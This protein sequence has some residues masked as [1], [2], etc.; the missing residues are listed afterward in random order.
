MKILLNQV[1]RE[2]KITLTKLENW[3]GISK[4]TLNNY[5]N[6]KTSPNMD[7][8]ENLAEALD[9]CIEDLYESKR[10]KH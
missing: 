2:R 3:T 6:G 10:K 7:Q 5:E 9:V 8:M 1:R 4:S